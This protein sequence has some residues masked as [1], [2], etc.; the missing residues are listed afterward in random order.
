[1]SESDGL[2]TVALRQ[3]FYRDGYRRLLGVV[4]ILALIA[5]VMVS[6][7]AYLAYHQ[8]K[9]PE[10]FATTQDGRI[11]P[12]YPLSSPIVS[13]EQLLQW[14]NQAAISVY[15]YSFV[16]YRKELQEAS[17]YFTP[18]G[19]KSFEDALTRSSNLETVIKKKLVSSAV[20][21]GAPVVEKRGILNGRYTWRISMPLL[22]TY[23]SAS[24]VIQQSLIVTMNIVRVP[25]I[26]TPKG[27]AIAQFFAR[28]G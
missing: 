26:N 22:I 20:A 28:P 24:D 8:K 9:R 27:I 5:V 10:Y 15:N 7:I 21:T 14:A 1:M 23:E 13:Q 12:I 17:D 3:N 19:W 18:E 6:I 16:N 4:T 2:E 25:V 11:L